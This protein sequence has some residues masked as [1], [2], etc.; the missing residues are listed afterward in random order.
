MNNYFIKYDYYKENHE[1]YLN[2]NNE[3]LSFL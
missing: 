1:N 3:N 2:Y